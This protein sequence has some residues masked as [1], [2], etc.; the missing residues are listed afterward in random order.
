MSLGGQ[1]EDVHWTS[2]REIHRTSYLHNFPECVNAV[3][4]KMPNISTL[5][6]RADYDTKIKD[7]V[8]NYF[9]AFDINKVLNN[10]LEA[11]ITKK[12]KLLNLILLVW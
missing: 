7:I 9:T 10:I 11:D 6:K 5:I 3:E 1:N 12:S 8:E 2:L 4:N